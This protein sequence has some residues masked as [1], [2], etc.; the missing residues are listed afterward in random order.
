MF[1]FDKIYKQNDQECN[2]SEYNQMY[3]ILDYILSS[4]DYH[5]S[6]RQYIYDQYLL[7]KEEERLQVIN[8]T[9]EIIK[10]YGLSKSLYELLKNK[11]PFEKYS[12]SID[13]LVDVGIY[14]EKYISAMEDI[15]SSSAKL[16]SD[17]GKTLVEIMKFVLSVAMKMWDFILN[18]CNT[19]FDSIGK[20]NTNYTRMEQE[21]KS[22]NPENYVVPTYVFDATN[23]TKHQALYTKFCQSKAKIAGHVPKFLAQIYIFLGSDQGKYSLVC[24]SSTY[25]QHIDKIKQSLIKDDFINYTII[26]IEQCIDDISKMKTNINL[27]TIQTKIDTRKQNIENMFKQT[28][29]GPNLIKDAFSK[30]Q[31]QYKFE[32][33]HM[34]DISVRIKD[35]YQDAKVQVN[36]EVKTGKSHISKLEGM[37]TALKLN[38]P[39]AKAI[40]SWIRSSV[41]YFFKYIGTLNLL[42]V[43][44][45]KQFTA[46]SNKIY[47]SE[48]QFK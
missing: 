32:L 35:F 42:I 21:L 40:T 5:S 41:G 29:S 2:L 13:H 12:I 26:Q 33:D 6:Y 24:D 23:F 16:I 8:Q 9:K 31:S 25:N 11:I 3:P 39:E 1:N 15:F 46:V 20:Y 34:K 14:N 37:V 27:S 4:S 18:M 44:L 10:Q 36:K 30:Q 7:K 17:I 43:K 48:T 38:Q 28:I 19:L 45:H 47:A 22:I